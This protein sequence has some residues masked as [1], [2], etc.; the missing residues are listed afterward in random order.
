MSPEM[1]EAIREAASAPPGKS[2]EIIRK[3]GFWDRAMTEDGEPLPVWK[4][5]F[6]V[7]YSVDATVFVGAET[8][9]DAEQWV[10]ER[11][12]ALA[13]PSDADVETVDFWPVRKA[14]AGEKPEFVVGQDA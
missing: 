7:S 6:T 3:A 11:A 5:D 9:K 10:R 12:D 13:A 2:T 14:P 1:R 8:A 4:V